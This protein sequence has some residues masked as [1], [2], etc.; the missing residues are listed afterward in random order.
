MYKVHGY[1]YTQLCMVVKTYS[2]FYNSYHEYNS[3]KRKLE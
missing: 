3:G 2:Q 1:D